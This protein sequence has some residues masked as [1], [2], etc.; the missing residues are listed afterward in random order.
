[1]RPPELIPV[2]DGVTLAVARIDALLPHARRCTAADRSAIAGLPPWRARQ[3]LGAR[4]LLRLALADTAGA[5]AARAP[6][7]V[8]GGGKP[9]LPDRPDLGINLSHDGE[10]A[11]AVV[12]DGHAVGVDVQ[13]PRAVSPG[14]LRRCCTEAT[15][16]GLSVLPA[17]DR[18]WEFARIWTVQEACV[19]ASGDG[20]PGRP[21]T[22]RVDLGR[23]HG[24]W[25]SYR[26]RSL[27]KDQGPPV[28]CAYRREEA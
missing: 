11:A 25:R 14:M 4:T 3:S 21:W 9:Y 18:E 16:A 8:R 23:Q 24:A 5:G 1:M 6:I 12:G 22:I 7:A 20:L 28:S 17:P 13:E 19:K 2:A 26:W 10:W 27:R 15:A